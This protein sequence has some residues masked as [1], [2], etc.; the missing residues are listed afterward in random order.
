LLE[1]ASTHRQ[2]GY[3]RD[4]DLP[5]TGEGFPSRRKIQGH[6]IVEQARFKRVGF[7]DAFV[8]V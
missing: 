5:K 3:G 1:Y 2:Q 4:R 7:G 6:Q 8:L